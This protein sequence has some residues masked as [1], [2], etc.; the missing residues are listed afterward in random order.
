MSLAELIR[1][2]PLFEGLDAARL[3][4]IL[5]ISQRASF[6]PGSHIVRQGQAADSAFALENGT[7]EVITALPGGGELKVAELGPGSILG[8]MALLENAVRSA[9]VIARTASSGYFI[10]RDAFRMLLAQRDDTAFEIQHR[11]TR[12]LCERLRDLNARI[13]QAI[14]P[15]T[16]GDAA[17]VGRQDVTQASRL[18]PE[19]DWRGFLPLLPPFRRLRADEVDELAGAVNVFALEP[20]APIFAE[21]SA[22]DSGFIVVRGA[23]EILRGERG[24]MRRIGVLGPGRMCGVLAMIEGEVHSMTARARERTVLMEIGRELFERLFYGH[25]RLAAKFQDAVNQ[26]LLQAL[27][28]T[29]NQLTRLISQARIR[30]HRGKRTEVKALETALAA[31][32]CT[33]ASEEP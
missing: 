21:G 4:P 5:R 3:E 6:S 7:V 28:R 27:A 12:T 17:L 1:S 19:F 18:V 33:A 26:E 16:D 31:Q 25:D 24:R 9:T 15:E 23:L 32:D 2:I 30:A 13:V 10:E 29:N 20:G 22:A 8:E 11:I 14:A